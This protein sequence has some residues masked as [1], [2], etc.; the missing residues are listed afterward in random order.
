MPATRSTREGPPPDRA[1]AAAIDGRPVGG[2][3][4]V[5]CF[6]FAPSKH[7]GAFG[8]GGAAVTGDAAL[9]QRMQRFA[10]YGQERERH[11][12]EGFAAP[13]LEHL[14][15]GLNERLDELQAAMLRAKLPHLR[16]LVAGHVGRAAAC[17]Q[18]LADTPIRTPEVRPGFVHSFRNYVVHLEDRDRVRRRLAEDGIAT[19]L[20]YASPLHRQPV[21]RETRAAKRPFPVADRLG[22]TLLSLPVGPHLDASDCRQVANRLA[23][24]IRFPSKESGGRD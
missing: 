6:S 24:A 7:L 3:A 22:K 10:G 15:E 12:R 13:P 14:S 19:G 21:Y 1:L 20:H 18:A 9:A 4:E 11:Y 8:S 2:W 23:A 5:T 16:D 17:S